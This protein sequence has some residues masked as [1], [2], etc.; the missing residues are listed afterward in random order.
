MSRRLK[1]VK[2]ILYSISETK[3]KY[4]IH[5]CNNNYTKVER[6]HCSMLKK[7]QLIILHQVRK[8]KSVHVFGNR[9][10]LQSCDPHKGLHKLT[11]GRYIMYKGPVR[12]FR[13]IK[14]SH[15]LKNAYWDQT[16]PRNK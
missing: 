1:S 4:T 10:F 13:F 8:E 14:H 6:P 2:I 16:Q 11:N 7:V 15:K 5:T 12:V 9:I 3:E